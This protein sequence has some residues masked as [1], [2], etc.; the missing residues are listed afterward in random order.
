M[1]LFEINQKLSETKTGVKSYK[2]TEM[3]SIRLLGGGSIELIIKNGTVD[4]LQIQ[5]TDEKI[6]QIKN[7][8]GV[9]E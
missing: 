3:H 2:I 6:R 4:K 5:G 8:L 7:I 1:T 9:V